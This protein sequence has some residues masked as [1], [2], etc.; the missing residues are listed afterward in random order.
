[1]LVLSSP[2]GAGK[3]TLARRLLD[4]DPA[5]SLSV[6]LTTRPPRDGE[7]DGRDYTFVDRSA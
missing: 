7:V 2:S 4:S 6:S 5:I 1:M 3:T